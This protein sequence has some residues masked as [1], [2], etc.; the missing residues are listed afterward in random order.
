[1]V[2]FIHLIAQ[3]ESGGNSISLGR[4]DQFL[5]PFYKADLEAGRTNPDE[6]RELL[7]LLYLKMNEIWNVLEE[8]YIPGGEGTDRQDHP[9]RCGGRD[10][11][12]RQRRDQ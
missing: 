4:I 2:Y 1:M 3:I 10:H 11:S 9:E 8:A 7:S 5:Y 12:R 6:A